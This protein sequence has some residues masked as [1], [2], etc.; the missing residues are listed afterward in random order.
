[1][2]SLDATALVTDPDGLHFLASVLEVTTSAAPSRASFDVG[3]PRLGWT[4][5]GPDCAAERPNCGSL[6]AETA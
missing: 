3:A 4:I 6:V 2:T 5:M 1:M